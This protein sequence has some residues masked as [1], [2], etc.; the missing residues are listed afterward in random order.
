MAVGDGGISLGTTAT[1]FDS[2]MAGSGVNFLD[3]PIGSSTPSFS[4]GIGSFLSDVTGLSN[5]NFLGSNTNSLLGGF[6]SLLSGNGFQTGT[7]GS[8]S[9]SSFFSDLFL[10][11]VV[12]ILGF[13]FVDVGLKMF[14]GGNK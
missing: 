3:A 13:I 12:I 4:S 1:G 6:G 5:N 7:A 8:A 14:K 9:S 10:R 11:A 2:S